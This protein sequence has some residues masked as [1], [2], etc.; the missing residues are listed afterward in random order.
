[1]L[2]RLQLLR[3]IIVIPTGPSDTI[4]GNFKITMIMEG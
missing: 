1:M 2:D 4:N 3:G